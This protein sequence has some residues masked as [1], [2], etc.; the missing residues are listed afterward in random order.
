MELR[1]KNKSERS[2]CLKGEW[3]YYGHV[4]Q[5]IPQAKHQERNRE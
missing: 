2:V 3:C 5:S 4:C 1:E